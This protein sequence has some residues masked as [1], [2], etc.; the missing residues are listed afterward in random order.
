MAWR[1]TGNVIEGM[2]DNTEAGRI[3]GWLD[4]A[5]YPHRV[6]LN[7]AGDMT[8]SLGGRRVHIS[9]K[10]RDAR[11]AD[12]MRG[13]NARQAGEAD[14]VEVLTD[15]TLHASWYGPN[16]RVCIELPAGDYEDLK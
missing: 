16:G 11:P 12:Y 6:V 4:F 8:G 3:T 15:G 2:L 9:R 13:F 5:N 7:L 10:D 1:P 14:A